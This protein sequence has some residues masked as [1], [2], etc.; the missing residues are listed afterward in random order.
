MQPT[1]ETYL[2]FTSCLLGTATLREQAYRRT[3]IDDVFMDGA[4]YIAG[5]FSY[6]SKV[7]ASTK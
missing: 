4:G 2:F 7:E 1:A 5:I 6:S 3:L